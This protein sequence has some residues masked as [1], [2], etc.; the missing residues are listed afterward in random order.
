[1]SISD[2]VRRRVE[3]RVGTTI[4]DKYRID[5]VLGIGGMGSVFAATHRTGGS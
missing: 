3:G 1:M 2:D 5:S 4:R